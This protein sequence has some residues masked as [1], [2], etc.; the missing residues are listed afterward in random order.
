MDYSTTPSADGPARTQTRPANHVDAA[1]GLSAVQALWLGALGLGAL[2]A[3]L[4]AGGVLAPS[5]ASLLAAIVFY[6]AVV[7]AVAVAAPAGAF[8]WPNLVTLLRAV[9]TVGLIGHVAESALTGYRPDL[10]GAWLVALLAGAAIL[11]DGLDG[12]IARRFRRETAF[13]ARFDMEIDALLILA[14]S[15]LAVVLDKAGWFALAI[16]GMRYAFVVA[17]WLLPALAGP[18]PPSLRRKTV[19]VVQGVTLVLLATPVVV[20]PVSESLAFAALAL[21]GYSF[22]VDIVWRLRLAR[23]EARA[24]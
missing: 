11:L 6:G 12:W 21:L 7:W 10:S 1:R 2:A 19:C 8:G 3:A 20:P 18:L 13:G 14:L 17:G 5:P 22:L 16:G 9:I 15:V 24:T 4:V 23:R